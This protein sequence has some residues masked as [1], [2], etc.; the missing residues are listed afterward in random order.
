MFEPVLSN[1]ANADVSEFMC[2]TTQL[3]KTYT[4]NSKQFGTML[5]ILKT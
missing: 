5:N 4:F 3:T 2:T 1:N